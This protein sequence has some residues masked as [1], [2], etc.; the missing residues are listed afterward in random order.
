MV[1]DLHIWFLFLVG[2]HDLATEDLM[3]INERGFNMT[4]QHLAHKI[5]Q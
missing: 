2:G 3:H 1:D 4:P 5:S